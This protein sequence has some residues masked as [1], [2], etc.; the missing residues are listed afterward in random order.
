M[1]LQLQC[2]VPAAKAAKR[3]AQAVA[4]AREKPTA[5]AVVPNQ[6]KPQNCR[7]AWREKTIRKAADGF[8][9][10]PH[11]D[12]APV[13]QPSCG[14]MLPPNAKLAS[15]QPLLGSDVPVLVLK[16]RPQPLPKVR[17]VVQVPMYRGSAAQARPEEVLQKLLPVDGHVVPAALLVG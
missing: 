6:R 7:L 4:S 9:L 1:Q 3:A 8:E 14:V 11:L 13:C 10:E 15:A 16:T 2:D 5:E 12:V 17:P